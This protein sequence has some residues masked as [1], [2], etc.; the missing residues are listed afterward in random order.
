M[1]R[2]SMLAVIVALVLCG[3]VAAKASKR[4]LGKM[5]REYVAG[6][7]AKEKP[8]FKNWDRSSTEFKAFFSPVIDGCVATT[9][10]FLRNEWAVYDVHHSLLKDMFSLFR[11]NS[12]G[13]NNVL[14]EKA[15]TFKGYLMNVTYSKFMD[16]GEGGTPATLKSPDKQYSR[17]KCEA[18]FQM[19]I[20]S[21]GGN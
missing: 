14:L 17:D 1:K 10:D 6:A 5:C 7:V 9:T 13:V 20:K 15:R 11:C 19:K 3:E 12:G 8:L 4:D 21:L 2:L 16:N 18:V